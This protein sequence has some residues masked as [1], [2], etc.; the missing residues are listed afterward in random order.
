V[1]EETAL[2]E[3]RARHD[4]LDRGGVEALRKHRVLN[5]PFRRVITGGTGGYAD[6]GPGMTQTL[7]GMRD[8]FGVRLQIEVDGASDRAATDTLPAGGCDE[9]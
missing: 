3:L 6:A 2:G 5:L 4:L 8:G 1:V 7:L 9:G